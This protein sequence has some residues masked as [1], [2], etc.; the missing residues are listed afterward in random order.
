MLASVVVAPGA[1]PSGGVDHRGVPLGELDGGRV[2]VAEAEAG[3][4][5][6]DGRQQQLVGI[7]ERSQIPPRGRA[8]V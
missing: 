5:T 2:L 1:V 6:V 8:L 4:G 3:D 7:A